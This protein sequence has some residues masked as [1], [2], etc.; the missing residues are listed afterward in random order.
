VGHLRE[1]NRASAAG[2][3]RTSHI[4]AKASGILKR[5]LQG[6]RKASPSAWGDVKPDMKL[7]AKAVDDTLTGAMGG[8]DRVSTM[9]D[10]FGDLKLEGLDAS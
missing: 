9:G 7:P 8:R 6:S 3:T 2:A 10:L 4:G 1:A 5:I